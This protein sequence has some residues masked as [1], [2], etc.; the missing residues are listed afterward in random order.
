MPSRPRRSLE[1]GE[2]AGLR[3]PWAL[4]GVEVWTG[5]GCPAEA[6]A[7]G[8]DGLIAACGSTE[9]VLPTLPRG[10]AVL[11]GRGA[12]VCPG[13][14]DPHVHVRASASARAATDASRA[15][16]AAELIKLVRTTRPSQ[17]GW[18]T[19]VGSH[20]G[21]PLTGP[22]PDRVALDRATATAPIRIRDR[23]GHGWLFN[24]RGLR[25]LGVELTARP[26]GE[27]D[28]DGVIVER[29]GDGHATGFIADHVGWVG[30]R[31]GPLSTTEQLTAAVSS[32]SRELARQ[33]VV[34]ICDATATNGEAQ[35]ATLLRWREQRMLMQE[36]T[37]LSSPTADRRR[38][39]A[40][41]HA[42]IKFAEAED[43]RLRPAIAQAGRD[44]LAVA[45]HCV[46]A[47]QTAAVL[48]A[49]RALAA[50]GVGAGAAAGAFRLEHA[51]F[52]PPDWL[53]D[54][55]RLGATVVT[56]PTFIEAHGDRY[57]DD[58]GLKPAE[59][60][61][62]LASWTRAGVPLAFASDAP[63]GPSDPLRALRAAAARRT[64][65]GATIGPSEALSGEHALRA[66][67]TV[68]ARCS[69]LDRFGYGRIVAGGPGAAVILSHDPRDPARL[70]ELELLATVIGGDVVD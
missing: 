32:W 70:D 25:S 17:A 1:R 45:V 16:D 34:A 29:D 21:T 3:A 44:R 39:D 19:L 26:G 40:R 61:Y 51:S 22:A 67:S 6:L 20:L 54:V 55:R 33:G 62:R 23:S 28:N 48:E 8:D 43:R 4:T 7:F 38:L 18:V 50:R 35:V 47:A 2:L 37:F 52:V 10:A 11:D 63:F 46:E 30:R 31:I 24:S 14:V 60:L 13:F 27:E 68:A 12:R 9:D 42:G 64:A 53:A 36:F 66:L 15:T 41:R 65:S 69:G 59:W 58:P 56:H 5:D 49:G 57:L